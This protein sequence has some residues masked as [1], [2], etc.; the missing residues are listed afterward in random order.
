LSGTVSEKRFKALD[1]FKQTVENKDTEVPLDFTTSSKAAKT[2][3]VGDLICPHHSDKQIEGYCRKDD[4]LLCVIWILEKGHKHHDVVTLSRAY[5]EQ[6]LY[7]KHKLTKLFKSKDILNFK[8]NS[9]NCILETIDGSHHKAVEEWEEFYDKVLETVQNIKKDS[10]LIINRSF[11]S[12]KRELSSEYSKIS[13]ILD[14]LKTL[15][16]KSS[17]DDKNRAAIK[18][19]Q[20]RKEIESLAKNYAEVLEV[21][22][23]IKKSLIGFNFNKEKLN[24][25]QILRNIS[26]TQKFDV[27]P[28]TKKKS[29]ASL[30]YKTDDNFDP[31]KQTSSGYKYKS[32]KKK[33][34]K[35]SFNISKEY[36]DYSH[37]EVNQSILS[38]R[39]GSTNSKNK[40]KQWEFSSRLT[41]PTLSSELKHQTKYKPN[42]E[43][44]S[45]Q[46][47]E[48]KELDISNS[49]EESE[50]DQVATP[51]ISFRGSEK[52]EEEK[53]GEKDITPVISAAQ[54]IFNLE[55]NPNFTKNVQMGLTREVHFEDFLNTPQSSAKDDPQS[56]AK[57]H[58]QVNNSQSTFK[59]ATSRLQKEKSARK[60]WNFTWVEEAQ[61]LE[62]HSSGKKL[63][64]STH[65]DYYR[66][67]THQMKELKK[68]ALSHRK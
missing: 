17:Q 26:K 36:D 40:A 60:S 7:V 41:G 3:R 59:A 18:F 61:L 66:E 5:K 43:T 14:T 51:A 57:D 47:I 35:S 11:H 23:T 20:K 58:S 19:L 64:K 25:L 39:S 44:E 22:L 52:G 12:Y 34:S 2:L 24:L 42:S 30:K 4:T 31:Y 65:L 28:F 10:L 55:G 45:S 27:S 21:D 1:L 62:K 13:Q 15:M 68:G 46:K 6:K 33:I 8:K 67:A 9:V 37:H 56:P 48:Q 49:E 53:E 54:E 63:K 38:H 16:A 29:R 32:L 50:S